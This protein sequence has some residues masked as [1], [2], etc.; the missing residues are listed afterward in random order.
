L[1][2]ATSSVDSESE[3]LIQRATEKLTKGRTS[4]VIAHRL[5]TIQSSNKII[6]LEKGEIIEEGTH[7]ELL[8]KNGYYKTLFDMQFTD[9]KM[10]NGE[11]Q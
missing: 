10:N 4:I 11:Q 6:V 8:S 2:E 3:E 5:S 1:D 7:G 9:D